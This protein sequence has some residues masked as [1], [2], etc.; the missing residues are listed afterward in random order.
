MLIARATCDWPNRDDQ[1][2]QDATMAAATTTSALT[3]ANNT[4]GCRQVKNFQLLLGWRRIWTREEGGRQA[5][6]WAQLTRSY[7]ELTVKAHVAFCPPA[8]I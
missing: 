2:E 7:S 1:D 4:A 5:G 8:D 6:K 3:A